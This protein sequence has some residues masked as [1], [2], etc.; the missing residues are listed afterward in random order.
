MAITNASPGGSDNF[1]VELQ[2]DEKLAW[3]WNI[4]G[5]TSRQ[6]VTEKVSLDYI[7]QSLSLKPGRHALTLI[8]DAGN[9]I[10]ESDKS[11]N[12]YFTEVEIAADLPDFRPYTPQEWGAPLV[13]ISSNG[14]VL[15]NNAPFQAGRSIGI[16]IINGGTKPSG[17]FSY[18]LTIDDFFVHTPAQLPLLQGDTR[19]ENVPLD[20]IIKT[21][22]L[23]SGKHTFQLVI[24]PQNTIEELDES[25]NRYSVDIEIAVARPPVPRRVPQSP[26]EIKIQRMFDEYT[27]ISAANID[28]V[29]AIAKEVFK[30]VPVDWSIVK[31]SALPFAEFNS[32]YGETFGATLEEK[33]RLT[34]TV[35]SSPL[36]GYTFFQG[37]NRQ[38]TI[39]VR[40]GLVL[41]ILPFIFREIGGGYYISRNPQ[42]LMR[43]SAIPT[44]ELVVDLSELYGLQVLRERFGWDGL[45]NVSYL[46]HEDAKRM[47]NSLVNSNQLLGVSVRI[48]WLIALESG[49][50]TG[51]V[52]SDIWLRKFFQFVNMSDPTDY[53]NSIV[54]SS[55]AIDRNLIISTIESRVVDKELTTI[56]ETVRQKLDSMGRHGKDLSLDLVL[57]SQLSFFRP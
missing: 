54:A 41:Q 49:Y 18:A 45:T 27:W 8:A 21:Y 6:V 16:G 51:A 30:E 4:D 57:I 19:V 7:I 46:V 44:Q 28:E 3:V 13:L 53:I 38:Q 52:P 37:D 32:R 12:Q 5:L 1:Y 24:D 35:A 29:V 23:K 55:Q 33:I 34:Q 56:P 39:V 2:V 22:N 47:V 26:A 15:K 42:G 17:N 9:Y 48:P 10:I 31:V 40:E 25:N 36:T 50:P 11:N 43:A 20:E 14:S